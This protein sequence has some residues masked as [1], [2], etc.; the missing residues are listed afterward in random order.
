MC[1]LNRISCWQ[2][3]G[4]LADD[5][6]NLG[7]NVTGLL[8]SA[9]LF[10]LDQASAETRVERRKEVHAAPLLAVLQSNTI[11]LMQ[12]CHCTAH[13]YGKH[14]LNLGTERCMSTR[15]GNGCQS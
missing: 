9:Y 4:A 2:G 11:F 8:V 7:V 14:R 3:A 15:M 12:R 6:H 1:V 10:Q 13:R 5:L